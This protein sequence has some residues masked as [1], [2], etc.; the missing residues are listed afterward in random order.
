[1]KNWK[2]AIKHYKKNVTKQTSIANTSCLRNVNPV[3]S[4]E[5]VKSKNIWI[6]K[7]WNTNKI[8]QDSLTMTIIEHFGDI[9]HKSTTKSTK[10]VKY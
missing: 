8:T 3:K 4:T 10:I 6:K 2:I 9:I 1:M 7:T 5:H